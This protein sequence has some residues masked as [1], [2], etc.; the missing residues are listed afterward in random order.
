MINGNNIFIS[1]DSNAATIPFAATKSNEIQTEC[2]T[3]E[4]SSPTVGDWRQYIAGRKEWSFTVGWLVVACGTNVKNSLEALLEVG[5]SY[6]I[7]ICDRTGSTATARLTGS[8][9]CTSAKITAT[10]GNIAVGSFSFKGNGALSAP[11]V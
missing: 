1:L 10:R 6:T 2:D 11:S 7:T 5:K 3:I 8:A 9:I 4:I